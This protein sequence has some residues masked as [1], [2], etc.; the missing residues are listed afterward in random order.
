MEKICCTCK[1]LIPL[2]DFAKNKSKSN[3][4]GSRCKACNRLTVKNHYEKNKERHRIKNKNR[5]TKKRNENKL[6]IDEI[7]S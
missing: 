4:Y 5:R 2:V 1:K 3:G 6:K 7:K